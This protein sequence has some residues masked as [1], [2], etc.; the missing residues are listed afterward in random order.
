ME[1]FAFIILLAY[2]AII[3]AFLLKTAKNF[4]EYKNAHDMYVIQMNKIIDFN[5]TYVKELEDKIRNLTKK[6]PQPPSDPADYWK[7]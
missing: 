2:A 6:P 7:E 3:T 1:I 4:E 5:N